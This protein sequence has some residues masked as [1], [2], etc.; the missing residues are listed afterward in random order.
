M[1][2]SPT[3]TGFVRQDKESGRWFFIGIEKAKDKIGHALRKACQKQKPKNGNT[4][5]SKKEDGQHVTDIIIPIVVS[6]ED[7]STSSISTCRP[8]HGMP[9]QPP[10]PQEQF[11]YQPPPQQQQQQQ[12]PYGYSSSDVP[13]PHVA[14][15][16][17][18]HH[19]HHPAPH[20]SYPPT[21]QYVD[22]SSRH[23]PAPLPY[24]HPSQQPNHQHYHEAVYC[25]EEDGEPALQNVISYEPV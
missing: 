25:K 6:Q 2:C 23:Y 21:S 24:H 19:H 4:S 22:Y 17:Y 5:N 7:T 1:A 18:Y 12:Q 20:Q 11:F 15:S 9:M 3:R 10:P 14:Y 16:S 8:P 13:P